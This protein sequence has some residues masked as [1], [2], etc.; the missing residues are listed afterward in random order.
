VSRLR[1]LLDR[2]EIGAL[3]IAAMMIALILLLPHL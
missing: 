2:E 3:I 1:D